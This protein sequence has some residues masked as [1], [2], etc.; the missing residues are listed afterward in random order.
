MSQPGLQYAIY[1]SR[2]YVGKRD[3][4]GN[5]TNLQW[6]GDSDVAKV[7]LTAKRADRKEGFTG[8]NLTTA[9]VIVEESA[10]FEFD[11]K[12]FSAANLALALN[13]PV[14]TATS[15]SVVHEICGG[16]NVAVG[17]LV[18]L[19][20]A[21]V[22]AVSVTDSSVSPVA[23]T[24][25][26]HYTVNTAAGSLNILALPNGFTG[27]LQ[28]SYSYSASSTIGAFTASSPEYW[29]RIEGTNTY[30][31]SS[32][33]LDLFRVKFEP[34]KDFGLIV[35]DFASIQVTG[36][37]LYDPTKSSASVGGNFLKLTQVAGQ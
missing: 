7:S 5:P 36:E 30:D 22:S 8:K 35:K 20:N 37:V 10:T 28:V 17:D 32:V 15:G 16:T 6:L 18:T 23:L 14:T 2:V 27:P 33:T 12:N 11:T 21:N 19:A 13:S 34:L 4:N 25:G 26:T 1:A 3:A 9:S 29:V 31:N 24:A